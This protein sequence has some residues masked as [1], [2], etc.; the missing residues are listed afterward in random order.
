VITADASV[1]HV[2][3]RELPIGFNPFY[4][5]LGVTAF[6]A[7]P[8]TLLALGFDFSTRTAPL[9]PENVAGLSTRDLAEAAHLAL[10]GSYS[11]TLLEW[12]ATAAAMFLCLMAF[13]QYRL[14][15]DISLPVIG[16][17]LVCAGAMD[18]FHTFAADR[19]IPAVADNQ[20]LIPFT[21]AICRLFNATIQLV[22]VGIV[23]TSFRDE[24]KQIGNGVLAVISGVFILAAYSIV[25]YC[26]NTSTL[27]QTTFPGSSITRPFDIYPLVPFAI[28]GL[29]VYPLYLRRYRNVFS[30]MLLISII[31]NVATQLYMA[32]GSSAL[33]DSAFNIAH[34][35]KAFS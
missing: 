1:S 33:H 22:G 4:W 29:V 21:W 34:G 28:L 3:Q 9:T 31:P 8:L 7:L 11:H 18:A 15:G 6:C 14:N 35:L 30:T 5:A 19:L 12:S 24:G 23:L 16:V 2:P 13:L 32:F 26:A 20:D 17:A 25:S 27:P 10:R